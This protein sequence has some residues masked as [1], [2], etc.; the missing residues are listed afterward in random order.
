MEESI[1]ELL[2]MKHKPEYVEQVYTF[3]E[4]LG[5]KN[6]LKSLGDK[7]DARQLNVILYGLIKGL[8]VG[9]Y[10][11]PD[12]DAEKMWCIRNLMQRGVD[13]KP[14]LNKSG[15]DMQKLYKELK[16]SAKK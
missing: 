11:K 2:E 10:A 7:F 12:Y 14:L 9:V 3:A 4:T 8:D 1:Y 5:Y 15:N 13:Y 16:N 6:E